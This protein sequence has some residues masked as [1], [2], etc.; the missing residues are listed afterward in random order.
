MSQRDLGGD[1]VTASYVSLLESG[2]RVPTLD[3]VIHLAK[4][5]KVSMADLLG[6]ELYSVRA[7]DEME[8]ALLLAEK[9]A[10][11]EADTADYAKAAGV[12]RAA[13][14][15]A[16]GQGNGLRALE[17]G[18]RLQLVYAALNQNDARV[19]LL[20]EL[21]DLPG[22]SASVDLQVALSTD[23]A[24]ALRQC[25]RLP[26]AKRV[27]LDA[28]DAMVKTQRCTLRDGSQHVKLL[29]VVISVLVEIGEIDSVEPYVTELLN[30][31]TAA[32]RVGLVGRAHW[33]A[34]HAYA[35]MGRKDLACQHL[36]AARRTMAIPSLPLRDWLRFCRASASVLL[37]VGGDLHDAETWLINAETA[38]AMLNLPGERNRTIAVRAR[39]HLANG[40]VSTC[41]DLID[42]VPQTATGMSE[43]EVIRLRLVRAEA[44]ARTGRRD[45]ALTQ[46]R[47]L[48]KAAERVGAFRLAVETW[49]QV[50]ALQSAGAPG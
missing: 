3:V 14:E 37:D 43:I 50:D 4:S 13:L 17:I 21:L 9:V 49:R 40:E 2:A 29:G 34:T 6:H 41:L 32:D 24:A 20:T 44:L 45:E 35:Q 1:V 42:T 8:S 25:G 26:A 27:A 16:V 28:L 7:A 39:Y 48:A 18:I 15:Q 5:L 12:L 23:L 33:V 46:T 30:V 38:A 10:F 36:S 22:A 11:D 47:I 31:A 19:D